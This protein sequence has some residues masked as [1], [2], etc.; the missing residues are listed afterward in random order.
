MLRQISSKINIVTLM[1]KFKK[2]T[3]LVVGDVMIDEFIWGTVSRISPEAP[4]PVVA[5]GREDLLLGGAANVVHNVHSL[6]GHVLIAGV[7]GDDRMGERIQELLHEEEIDGDGLITESGRPTTVKTR[8]IAHSQQVVR[9]DR[10]YKEPISLKSQKKI[11]GYV[12]SHWNEVD[13]IIIS[14]YGKGLLY[15]ELM[16][17]II[18][19]RKKDS[20]VIAVDP[21]MNNFPLYR[22]VTIVTP[23]RLEAE[24][25]AGIQITDE[26]SLIKVGNTLLDRFA[27]EA[28]LITRGEEGMV[29]FERSGTVVTVPTVAKEVYDVT[30][31]GDTVISTLTLS[32]ASGSSYS[33]AAVVANYAAG[34]VVGKIGT[35]TVSPEE[36]QKTIIEHAHL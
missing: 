19:K 18:E 2:S 33:E 35:A 4:V 23:N 16:K 26:K 32:L 27:S 13:G 20:K 29:L 10:E 34:I 14:D 12:E 30:G 9:F 36:L 28:V 15:P 8:V 17:L 3:L 7:I 5:V 22:G 6:G 21:K 11:A 31:A 1:E 25:A 24:A